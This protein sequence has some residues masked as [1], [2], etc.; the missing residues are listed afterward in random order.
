MQHASTF[1]HPMREDGK[2]D[3]IV[4]DL[5]KLGRTKR[6]LIVDRGPQRR[7]PLHSIICSMCD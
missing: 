3:I 6:Q 7:C 1:K 5:K 4:L 2:E